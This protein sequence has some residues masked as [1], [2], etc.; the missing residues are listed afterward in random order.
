MTIKN[1]F[2]GRFDRLYALFAY[3]ESNHWGEILL[4]SRCEYMYIRG[5]GF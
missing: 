4:I 2:G 1:Q 5:T 3:K